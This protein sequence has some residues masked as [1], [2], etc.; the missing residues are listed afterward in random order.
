MPKLTKPKSIRQAY[1]FIAFAAIVLMTSCG[2][3]QKGMVLFVNPSYHASVVG[4]EH[5]GFT[6]PDGILW[7]HGRLYIADEGGSAFRIWSGPGS[8]TTLSDASN[9]I[10]SPEDMAVDAQGNIFFTDDD[11]GGVWKINNFGETRLIAGKEQ[12]M[13]STEGIVLTPDGNL[14]VGD[15]EVHKVFKVTPDGVVSVFL[16]SEYGIG[17]A[18]SMVFDAKGNL[19]IADNDAR[20]VYLLTPDKA[21]HRLIHDREGFSPETLWF[22]N[23][24]LYITDSDDG[25]LFKYTSESDLQPIAVFGG[26]LA[27]INGITSD[28]AGAIYVSIQTDLKKKTGYILKL[29]QDSETAR[30]PLRPL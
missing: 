26:R 4:T 22:A 17:K 11:K 15:G 2:L 21:L 8:V 16:G 14:L 7:R 20:T 19:Y 23:G 18:E 12:G 27:K 24:V 25:K 13:I 29:A 9:G 6:V 1:L 30:N 5:D 28:D 10:I 3:D